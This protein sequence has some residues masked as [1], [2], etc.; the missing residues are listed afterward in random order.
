MPRL[1]VW[2]NDTI[3]VIRPGTWTDRYGDEIQED[4]DHPVETVIEHCKVTPLAGAEDP[5]R[6]D[7]RAA[8]TKRW[9]V[10]APPC[11]DIRNSDRIRWNDNDYEVDGDVLPW[12]SPFG[13][14]DHLRAEIRRM[15][16]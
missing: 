10:A 7:D 11:S 15:E 9:V 6:L 1:P 16:G 12:T 2:F 8:L 4:W 3:T 13:A 14:A 5:G